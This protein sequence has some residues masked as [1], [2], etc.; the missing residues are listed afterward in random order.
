MPPSADVLRA[1]QATS[2]RVKVLVPFGFTEPAETERHRFERDSAAR[3]PRESVGD[4]RLD[5]ISTED[6]QRSPSVRRRP[7]TTCSRC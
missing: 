7:S 1:D 4:R 2:E 5:E 3:A 6:V